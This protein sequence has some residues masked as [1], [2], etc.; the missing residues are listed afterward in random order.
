MPRT[1][2]VPTGQSQSVE[3]M[4]K[5]VDMDEPTSFLDHTRCDCK[6]KES[7]IEQKTK[8]FESRVSAGATVKFPGWDKPR[9]KTSAW[10]YDMEGHARKC[11]ERCCELTSKKVEQLYKVDDIQLAGKTENI[12]PT[13]KILMKDVDPGEPTSF[14][15]HVHLG[16]TRKECQISNDIVVKYRDMFESRISGGAKKN[17]LQELQGNLMQKSYL[18]RPNDMEGHAKKCVDR[19]CELA[20]KTML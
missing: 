18:L 12:E 14:L 8:M 1:P 10:S 5:N 6:A 15:D 16:C 2:S 17:Y 13:W 11:V 3:K 9:A 20:N 19:Y 7:I 4:L